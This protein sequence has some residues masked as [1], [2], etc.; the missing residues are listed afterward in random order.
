[1]RC[2]LRVIEW[3]TYAEI[4]PSHAYLIYYT[5]APYKTLRGD[6]QFFFGSPSNAQ[7][8]QP[9][10]SVLWK[11]ETGKSKDENKIRTSKIEFETSGELQSA[12]WQK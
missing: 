9:G 5:V 2:L 6:K 11:P 10:Y 4:S 1:M 12:E 7:A 8:A 3:H